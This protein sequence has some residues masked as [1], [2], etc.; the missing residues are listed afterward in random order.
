M[1]PS[2]EVCA[3]PELLLCSLAVHPA[4]SYIGDPCAAV[5][6]RTPHFSDRDSEAQRGSQSWPNGDTASLGQSQ[7]KFRKYF[8]ETLLLWLAD[9][10]DKIQEAQL[11]LNFR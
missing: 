6:V 9:L 11:N 4:F 5:A 10:A 3:R 7:G 8:F 1:V 2:L